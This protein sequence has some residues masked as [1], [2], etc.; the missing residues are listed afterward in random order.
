MVEKSTILLFCVSREIQ[1]Y[2]ITVEI[3]KNAPLYG[4]NKKLGRRDDLWE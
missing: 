4:I 1:L 2:I 3:Y